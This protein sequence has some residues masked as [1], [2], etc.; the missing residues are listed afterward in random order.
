MCR[1]ACQ[2]IP[3]V[4]QLAY[5]PE[6]DPQHEDA[7]VVEYLRMLCVEDPAIAI[8]ALPV[9]TRSELRELVNGASWDMDIKGDIQVL[10][11]I[12]H[13]PQC[14]FEIAMSI[15]EIYGAVEISRSVRKA[16]GQIDLSETAQLCLGFGLKIVG[17]ANAGDYPLSDDDSTTTPHWVQT[18]KARTKE[19][20]EFQLSEPTQSRIKDHACAVYSRTVDGG[21][22][23]AVTLNSLTV[24]TW[25]DPPSKDDDMAIA[26]GSLV[27]MLEKV[28]QSPASDRGA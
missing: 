12:A 4:V 27:D 20:P 21:A 28:V 14:D 26:M 11:A 5:A 19:T 18:Y 16:F 2:V 7:G 13:L 24:W 6:L 15:L 8:R 3:A 23:D 25:Q 9:A 10:D 1:L 17:R 22:K